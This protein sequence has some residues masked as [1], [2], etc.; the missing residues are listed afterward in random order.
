[1][2]TLI[3]AVDFTAQPELTDLIEE[4]LNKLDR[5][6]DRVMEARVT[7]RVDKSDT[8]ENKVCEIKLAIP[9]NDLFVKKQADSFEKALGEAVPALQRQ[10]VEWKN[11]INE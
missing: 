7:L 2:K 3:Q 10:L 11:K 8:R 9:G 5:F 1:M 6:S 4:K